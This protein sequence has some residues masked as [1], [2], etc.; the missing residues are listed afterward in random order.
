MIFDLE[1]SRS[2]ALSQGHKV[3]NL[4]TFLIVKK[5]PYRSVKTIK[6]SPMNLSQCL[7]YRHTIFH[8]LIWWLN[9]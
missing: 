4:Y 5:A 1:K 3:S 9:L 2:Q 8:H 7:I 6:L